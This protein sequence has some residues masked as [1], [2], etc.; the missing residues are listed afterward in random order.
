MQLKR[1]RK[2]GFSLVEIIVAISILMIATVAIGR[3]IIGAQNASHESVNATMLEQRADR[4]GEKLKD[5]VLQ[6]DVGIVY[7]CVT[8][9]ASSI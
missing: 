2:K 8:G 5:I 4:T 7:R 6:T 3:V 9:D 1:N